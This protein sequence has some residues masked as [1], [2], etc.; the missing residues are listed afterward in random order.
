M[1]SITGGLDNKYS[2]SQNFDNTYSVMDHVDASRS[3]EHQ[4][5]GSNICTSTSGSRIVKFRLSD[6]RAWVG[7]SS[8]KIEY[9]IKNASGVE[10]EN[11]YP[12]T[13]HG[14]FTRMRLMS[15]GSLI[16]DIGEYNRV[17]EMFQ[18]LK[19]DNET[20]GD[21]I[22]GFKNSPSLLIPPAV[23][24]SL[25]SFTKITPSKDMVVSFKPL[26]GLLNQPQY[27]PLSFLPLE[28]ELE[29]SSNP[30]ANIIAKESISIEADRVNISENGR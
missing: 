28:L 7:P 14:F 18:N 16:E 4:A 20:K 23:V 27:I 12:I 30:L 19:S 5:V 29:L 25:S 17:H 6:D 21:F 15:R 11:L 9:R 24:G 13:A 26:S 10:A 22:E 8:I 1:K 2:E 3:V